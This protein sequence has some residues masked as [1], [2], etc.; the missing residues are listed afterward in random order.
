MG[1]SDSR[2]S[3]LGSVGR[4]PPQWYPTHATAY[5]VCV[6]GGHFTEVTCLGMPSALKDYRPEGNAYGNPFGTE[7]ALLRTSE[8]GMAR[9]IV[10]HF[11]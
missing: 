3:F 8:G 5:Y 1:I 9:M 2:R 7:A 11:S 10:P 4:S 6:T